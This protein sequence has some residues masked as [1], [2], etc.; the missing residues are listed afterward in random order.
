MHTKFRVQRSAQSQNLPLVASGAKQVLVRS[1]VVQVSPIEYTGGV[2]R[3]IDVP[4]NGKLLFS[5][6]V[7]TMTFG[8]FFSGLGSIWEASSTGG[9]KQYVTR[10]AQVDAGDEWELC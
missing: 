1:D 9:F 8:D 4:T 2:N 6:T 7:K 10:M 5:G 3:Y